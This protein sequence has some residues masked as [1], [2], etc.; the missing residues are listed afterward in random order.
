MLLHVE[1]GSFD[2]KQQLKVTKDFICNRDPLKSIVVINAGCAPSQKLKENSKENFYDVQLAIEVDEKGRFIQF[3]KHP[4]TRCD[5]PN[6][7]IF[8][9]HIGALILL[10]TATTHLNDSF[11]DKRNMLPSPVNDLLTKPMIARY[12]FPPV[13]SKINEETKLYR[14]QTGKG[15]KKKGKAGKKNKIAKHPKQKSK[16][17][18]LST[19][20]PHS[21]EEI[22]LTSLDAEND[23]T[24]AKAAVEHN[25]CLCTSHNDLIEFA[26]EGIIDASTEPTIQVVSAIFKWVKDINNGRDKKGVKLKSIDGIDEAMRAE[27]ELKSSNRYKLK[28]LLVMEKYLE[29]VEELSFDKISNAASTS[30]ESSKNNTHKF[31]IHHPEPITQHDRS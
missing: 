16:S 2:I 20:Q 24:I 18:S 1:G 9:A 30:D 14:R 12:A 10:L 8:C 11:D 4:Y 15:G 5:C 19:D 13:K 29:V 27:A 17:K 28:Q 7:C 23:S 31:H 6:G 26:V 22:V 3:L 25:I 21:I